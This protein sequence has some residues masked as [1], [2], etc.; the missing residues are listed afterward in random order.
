MIRARFVPSSALALSFC[1]ALAA[2][3]DAPQ[4]VESRGLGQSTSPHAN[5]GGASVPSTF[6]GNA[7]LEGELA[8]KDGFLMVSVRPVGVR[9]PLMTYKLSLQ[10]APE[11]VDGR[12]VVPFDLNTSSNVL[13]SP[14]PPEVAEIDLEIS[15][16]FDQDGVIETKE[17]DVTV[18][19]LVKPGDTGIEVVLG[20]STES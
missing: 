11:A 9:M 6:T 12:R 7:V 13:G 17:G 4:P 14:L 15:I 10:N 20:G 16:R 19:Q 8:N 18:S 2:C 5:H 3:G 1:L